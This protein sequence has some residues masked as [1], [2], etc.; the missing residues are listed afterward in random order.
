MKIAVNNKHVIVPEGCTAK[1]LCDITNLSE[2]DKAAI[3]AGME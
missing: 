2:S 3:A 1:A